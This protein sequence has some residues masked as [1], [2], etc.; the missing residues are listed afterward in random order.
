MKTYNECRC[1]LGLKKE[2]P[3]PREVE[4]P[5]TGTETIAIPHVGGLHHRYT[6]RAA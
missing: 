1:H 2:A 4:P 5:E 6:R 3:E